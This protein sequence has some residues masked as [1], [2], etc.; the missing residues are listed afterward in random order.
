VKPFGVLG[1]VGR[2]AQVDQVHF[3]SNR[4][5]DGLYY[6][7]DV[8]CELA[9]EDFNGKQLGI[10]RL[11]PDYSSYSSTMSIMIEVIPYEFSAE[12]DSDTAGDA[13]DMRMLRIDPA[14]NYRDSHTSA[15][16]AVEWFGY[17]YRSS[18]VYLGTSQ[19]V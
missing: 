6:R 2:E 10:G 14:V 19:P 3:L 13:T 11:L 17:G 9:I 5:F 15:G 16:A 8:G 18:H 4:P 1:V 12:V 7:I